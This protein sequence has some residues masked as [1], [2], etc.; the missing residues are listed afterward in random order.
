MA[1]DPAA[2]KELRNE[3]R[4]LMSRKHV[5]QKDLLAKAETYDPPLIGRT[6]LS[7]VLSDR[8]PC[9][10]EKA[11]RAIAK[12]LN[13]DAAVTARLLALRERADL[14]RRDNPLVREVP[15]NE[16]EIH[17]AALAR[18]ASDADDRL[19]PYFKRPLDSELQQAMASALE[20]GASVFTVLTGESSTGKTRA[21]YEA[22]VAL[23]PEHPL[24]RPADGE[25]LV[26]LVTGGRI[27]PGVVL[28]LNETQR[29]LYGTSGEQAAVALQRCLQRQRGVLAVGTLWHDPYW[30][31][32]TRR[33]VPRDPH[34]HARA[35]L[36][37]PLTNQ[38]AVPSELVDDEHRRWFALAR[39]GRDPRMLQA[40]DA[41]QAD[42]K[43]I[44]HLSGGP[45]LL[46]AYDGGPG[47]VFNHLEHALITA[48]VKARRL[49]HRAP[50][51]ADLLIAVADGALTPRL[52]DPNSGQALETLSS[53]ARCA[54][55]AL[56]EVRA[57]MRA[58]PKYVLADYLDQHTRAR[59]QRD[60]GSPTLWE[61][62]AAH[63]T[64]PDD[65][66]RL[67]KA[68]WERDF[69]KLAL[70][71]TMKATLAGSHQAP[72]DLV[73]RLKGPLDPQHQ[74][75]CWAAAHAGLPD[76]WAVANLLMALHE[77]VATEAVAVLLAR[78]VPEWA[79]HDDPS[80][81]AKLLTALHDVGAGT[82]LD[83]VATRVAANTDVTDPGAVAAML[84]A[85]HAAG[86]LTAV[87]TLLSRDPV[88][89]AK[90]TPLGPLVDLLTALKDLGEEESFTA[91]SHRAATAGGLADPWSTASLLETLHNAD[92]GEAMS[93][94]LGRGPAEQADVADPSGLARLLQTLHNM[95]ER[96]AVEFLARRAA[97]IIDVTDPSAAATVL[98]AL[99]EVAAETEIEVLLH[100]SPLEQVPL[101]R[102][103]PVLELLDA[104]KNIG[105]EE[106]FIQLAHHAAT[107]GDLTDANWVAAFLK[108]LRGVG[109]FDV[110]AKLVN[111]QP[112]E[113]VDLSDQKLVFG[114]WTGIVQL[115]TELHAVGDTAG[116]ETLLQR[117][118]DEAD[119]DDPVMVSIRLEELGDAGV[120]GAAEPLAQ[121]VAVETDLTDAGATGL[122]LMAMQEVDADSAIATLLSR[123]PARAADI[124]SPH[125]I[126]P[127]LRA[128]HDVGADE[129]VD[130]LLERSPEE[131]V[132]L[133]H[134]KTVAAMLETLRQ[135]GAQFAVRTLAE[136]IRQEGFD[137]ADNHDNYGCEVAGRPAA[138]WSWPDVS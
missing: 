5:R 72:V 35:L 89:Q 58:E 44:Q 136:R 49:G 33:G 59:Y 9:P 27:L 120:P 60:L 11:V 29:F 47:R 79:D 6:R 106:A 119:L 57:S 12:L 111:R 69:R 53:S 88:G 73:R 46:A 85:L 138:P 100:H 20:G 67:A 134:P 7:Q 15:P 39:R 102:L 84:Q 135:L 97:T 78:A 101:N 26:S 28:W 93:L 32:L 104:L 109:A 25:E 125:T 61:A 8:M 113:H 127:L 137:A 118:A 65:L 108:T 41:G 86:T 52:R 99:H 14:D 105:R 17:G 87:A 126:T 4:E 103:A 116:V 54:L 128:L 30:M 90:M 77:A 40:L 23:A 98:L 122:M 63:T 3:L 56:I 13:L 74:G 117:I 18:R 132:A 114:G 36:T 2:L 42:G 50:F 130:E 48:A 82:A 133:S 45:E 124:T 43:V 91:L 81:V 51:T 107:T 66:D 70:R 110:I 121:R 94:L 55:P 37:G 68:A 21:L 71:L 83:L 95:S 92:A 22:L 123:G 64:D 19:T 1:G 96:R 31:E 38:I 75:A 16:L 10:S 112:A 76:P 62:L 34:S 115:L 24:L 131:H 80:G 129:A